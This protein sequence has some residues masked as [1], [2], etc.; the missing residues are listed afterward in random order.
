M[1]TEEE[2]KS[3]GSVGPDDATPTTFVTPTP[4]WRLV[5]TTG[6][7]RTNSELTIGSEEQVGEGTSK[8]S[9]GRWYAEE[10]GTV[11]DEPDIAGTMHGAD[12]VV[13]GFHEASTTCTA[14]TNT[15]NIGAASRTA[16]DMSLVDSIGSTG[17][18]G[19]RYSRSTHERLQLRARARA[20]G[21]WLCARLASVILFIGSMALTMV[22]LAE[23]Y[24][25]VAAT[26]GAVA[27][28]IATFFAARHFGLQPRWLQRPLEQ[29]EAARV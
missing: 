18:K 23:K 6:T 14:S 19:S 8:D 9:I 17:S 5:E 7:R 11:Q 29:E 15:P 16:S 27:F 2:F 28:L 22:C 4:A 20:H 12:R 21:L 26:F 25:A 10:S 1:V 3:L 13:V 24:L